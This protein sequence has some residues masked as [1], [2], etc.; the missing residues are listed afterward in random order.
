[1]FKEITLRTPF[2]CVL[3]V[4]LILSVSQR[5]G[6]SS[7]Q[8]S[9]LVLGCHLA[10]VIFLLFMR[11]YQYTLKQMFC[12]L[13]HLFFIDWKHGQLYMN[14]TPTTSSW[15]PD[16]R[17]F[18]FMQTH[19]EHS[20]SVILNSPTSLYQETL[21]IIQGAP[22]CPKMSRSNELS[23]DFP[24]KKKFPLISSIW[25]RGQGLCLFLCLC[26]S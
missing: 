11:E 6:W 25:P 26:A 2:V 1:M 8:N 3:Y 17:L 15:R 14:M 23:N 20:P 21:T 22:T 7:M 24:Q 12:L 9:G 16:F 4:D 13:W 10:T 18:T 5:L 19:P